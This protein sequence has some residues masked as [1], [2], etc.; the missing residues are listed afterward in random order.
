MEK[1]IL[2]KSI[3]LIGLLALLGGCI[4]HVSLKKE[5]NSTPASYETSNVVLPG[6]TDS[7]N[8]AKI[9]W[10][11]YFDDENLIALIDTALRKNQELNITLQEIEIS[12]NEIRARK[13][14]YLPFVDIGVAVGTEKSAR[15]TRYG[16]V[17]ENL[18]I[19][20]GTAF[21][22]PFKI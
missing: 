19:K 17:D 9:N 16:A 5:N 4:T 8:I 3:V 11:K 6:R 2:N 22:E 14:E 10:K 15:F 18:E 21:R 13:G 7:V 1:R 12:K 20:P